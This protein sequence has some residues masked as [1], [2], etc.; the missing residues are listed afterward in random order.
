MLS[1]DELHAEL[2]A[3]LPAGLLPWCT[4]CASHHARRPLLAAA[5]L[6]GELCLAGRAGRQPAF[7]RTDQWLGAPLAPVDPD[8]ARA[9]LARRYLRC[10]A[11]STPDRLAA[12][13]GVPRAHAERCWALV[14][15]ELAAAGDGWAPAA[16]ADALAA[17]APAAAAGVRLLPP[18]DPFLLARDRERLLGDPAARKRVWRPAGAPGVVLADGALAGLWRGRKRGAVW[19]VS[20]EPFAR[21]RRADRAGIEAEAARLAPFRGCRTADVAIA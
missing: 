12:W 14:A 18:G 11:P 1:R 5:A 13:A 17:P 10:Y 7:A 16:D 21:L 15:G 19:A 8:A 3:R 6:R 2:R 9:G 4:V 20:V